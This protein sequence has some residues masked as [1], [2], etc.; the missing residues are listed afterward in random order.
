MC[1][2]DR[3]TVSVYKL[4]FSLNVNEGVP[5]HR[6]HSIWNPGFVC[7]YDVCQGFVSLLWVT[8]QKDNAAPICIF[9]FITKATWNPP[10]TNFS[11]LQMNRD[12]FMDNNARNKWKIFINLIK[13]DMPNLFDEFVQDVLS[14]FIKVAT[15]SPNDLSITSPHSSLCNWTKWA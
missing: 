11:V 7:R 5:F 8:I 2:R 9:V 4:F 1:I 3:C 10:C 6:L 15:P 12:N 13:C 14:P